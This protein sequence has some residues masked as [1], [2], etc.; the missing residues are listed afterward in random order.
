MKFLPHQDPEIA[1]IIS[2]EEARIEGTLNLIAAENH[3]PQSVLEAQGSVF[4]MKA[5]EGYP[6]NRFH[7]GCIHAD[8]L[9][10]LAVSVARLHLCRRCRRWCLRI[11]F[12]R[13]DRESQL[14]RYADVTGFV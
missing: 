14:D 2:D 6:G 7:A 1:R 13:G 11:A 12:F 10:A 4:S 5:A 8:E 3:P 9:E